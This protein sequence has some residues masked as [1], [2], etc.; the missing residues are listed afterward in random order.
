MYTVA[1]KSFAFVSILIFAF[2][3]LATAPKVTRASFLSENAGNLAVTALGCSGVLDKAT[4]ALSTLTSSVIGQEVPTTDNG[5][6]I[7]ENCLDAIAYT[8]SKI[9]LAKITESTLNWINSGFDGSPTFVQEPGSF[10]ESIANERI[11][12]FTA[13]IGFDPN[14]Y[15]FGRLTAQNIIN[16]IQNQLDYN[17][18][19]SSGNLLNYDNNPNI[20]YKQRFD[21]YTQDFFYGGGWDG[22]LA[23]TQITEANPFDSYIKSVNQV[24]PTINAAQQQKNPIT[25][26]TQE[27]QQ[28]GGF[29]ALKKCVDPSWYT[30]ERSDPTFTRAEATAQS[31]N[32]PN[33]A[34]TQAAREW[35]VDHTCL[36]YETK[37]PGTA[38]AQQLNISTSSVNSQLIN[39]DELNES[40]SAVFDALIKQ[41]FKEGVASLSGED[42]TNPGVNVLGGY[43][44]NTGTST[45]GTGTGGNGSNSSSQWFNQVQN[46]D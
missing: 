44:N 2:S 37:T 9:V 20:P 26:I 6:H 17:A 43:G 18:S 3:P 16:S 34:D 25:Q 5:T 31:K 39:A 15:P 45:I 22:Y 30:S 1:K 38:I 10:F 13:Q 24:G 12:T 42:T 11:S 27:L 23:V 4:S 14:R 32:D 33:D 46:F 36:R 21:N 7:K 35:L 29:L 40:I 41:L 28:S 19:V 8:A